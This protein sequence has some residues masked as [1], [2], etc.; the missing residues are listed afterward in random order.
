MET[1]NLPKAHRLWLGVLA[2]FLFWHVGYSMAQ[3]PNELDIVADSAGVQ[4]ATSPI[5]MPTVQTAV[6]SGEGIVVHASAS[7]SISPEIRQVGFVSRTLPSGIDW[8]TNVS[9]ARLNLRPELLPD[10]GQAKWDVEQ[11]AD[12]LQR[13]L[14]TA[15]DDRFADW[16]R[17]LKWNE[18]QDE[19]RDA[20]PEVDKLIQLERNMRQNYYGLEMPQFVRLRESLEEYISA[21]R[22]GSDKAASWSR[23]ANAWISFPNRCKRLPTVPTRHASGR[24]V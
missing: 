15:N 18:L 5:S 17:F 19:L 12:Q 23:S 22:F 21:L 9:N 14:S 16:L 13:F 2:V 11:A 3:M 6:G 7:S 10:P 20:E 1:K 8:A 24:S 4:L